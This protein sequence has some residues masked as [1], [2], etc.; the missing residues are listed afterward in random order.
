MQSQRDAIERD[1]RLSAKRVE[2]QRDACKRARELAPRHVKEK[3]QQA[4]NII[5]AGIG[6]DLRK[7]KARH[8][9]LVYILNVGNVYENLQCHLEYGLQR[10]LPAAVVRSVSG[11]MATL[12]YSEQWPGLKA[13]CQA[14]YDALSE[15][16]PALQAEYDSQITVAEL[17]LNYYSDPKFSQEEN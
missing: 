1:A 7:A 13:E 14:E 4:R 6:Q 16:L 15:Q 9:D 12:R 3:V 11:R 5:D 2:E 8:H 10:L 17:A